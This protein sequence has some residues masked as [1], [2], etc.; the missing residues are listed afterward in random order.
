[1][2]DNLT[3][4]L[5][6]HTAGKP[7]TH[8]VDCSPGNGTRYRLWI[9]IS[10]A[11]NID[12]IAW[13]DMRWSCGD[14][15]GHVSSDWIWHGGRLHDTICGHPDADE[16]ARIANCCARNESWGKSSRGGVA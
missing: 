11:G 3:P 15:G 9:G 14:L 2:A 16:I 13:P 10:A 6:R 4:A 8:K 7:R 1:M 5:T 12:Y